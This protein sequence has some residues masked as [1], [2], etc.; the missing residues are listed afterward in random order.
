MMTGKCCEL[1]DLYREG[2]DG[3]LYMCLSF[4]G[5]REQPCGKSNAVYDRINGLLVV[6]V[7]SSCGHESGLEVVLFLGSYVL[8]NE[9]ARYM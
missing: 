8:T 1:E 3:C 9:M 4:W 7:Y 5:A 6:S 2:E